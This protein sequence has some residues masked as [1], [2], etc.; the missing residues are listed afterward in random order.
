MKE[1]GHIC[2]KRAM[3]T[4]F[5]RYKGRKDLNVFVIVLKEEKAYKV[6]TKQCFFVCTVFSYIFYLTQTLPL[7]EFIYI[8]SNVCHMRSSSTGN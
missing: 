1:A 7:H 3:F 8:S 5:L 4:L 6:G 2:T